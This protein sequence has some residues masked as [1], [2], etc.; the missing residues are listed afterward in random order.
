MIEKL[1]SQKIFC[2][3][4]LLYRYDEPN[5]SY[6]SIRES[7]Y[8][9]SQHDKISKFS[10]EF[11]GVCIR[12]ITNILEPIHVPYS[13]KKMKGGVDGFGTGKNLLFLLSA[14]FLTQVISLRQKNG[15]AKVV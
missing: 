6:E 10:T 9:G 5:S 7:P 14:F 8:W 2:I 15:N 1:P 12:G 4:L 13:L 11:C 3:K